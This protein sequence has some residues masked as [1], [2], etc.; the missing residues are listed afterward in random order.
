[1]ALVQKYHTDLNETR[2]GVNKCEHYY[3]PNQVKQEYYNGKLVYN[4]ALYELEITDIVPLDPPGGKDALNA[5]HNAI[6]S[7]KTDADGTV[8][9]EI[10]YKIYPEDLD[11]PPND[12]DEPIYGEFTVVQDITGL[13]LIGTYEQ[14]PKELSGI[15]FSDLEI[16]NVYYDYNSVEKMIPAKG[17]EAQLVV[18]YRAKK[19][20]RYTTGNVDGGYEY[21]VTTSPVILTGGKY[22]YSHVTFNDN[23]E[24]YAE[25][26]Y[27]SIQQYDFK[28][29]YVQKLQITI[30]FTSDEIKD[31]ST[32]LTKEWVSSSTSTDIICYQQHNTIEKE[33]ETNKFL[34]IT[35]DVA[36]AAP[37]TVVLTAT[38]YRT[39]KY[40]YTSKYNT[41]EKEEAVGGN[42]HSYSSGITSVYP[43][44]WTNKTQLIQVNVSGNY[45]TKQVTHTVTITNGTSTATATI[46]QDG[47]RITG[48]IKRNIRSA[49]EVYSEEISA[50][51]TSKNAVQIY[52]VVT[53]DL[54]NVWAS[55]NETFLKNE[56]VGVAASS[57]SGNT[58]SGTGGTKIGTIV[59]ADSRGTQPD[60][61]SRPVYN[62]TYA[63]CTYE[64]NT[65]T[66][67]GSYYV[68]QE[69]NMYQDS[70]PVYYLTSDTS[71]INVDARGGSET[72]TVYSYAQVL[73]TYSSTAQEYADTSVSTSIK[74]SNTNI[75]TVSPS[76]ITGK[77]KTFTVTVKPNTSTSSYKYATVTLTQSSSSKQLTVE[78][79]QENDYLIEQ[80]SNYIAQSISAEEIPASGGSSQVVVTYS[81]TCG[82][83]SY[84]TG[85]QIGNG[86]TSTQTVNATKL[87]TNTSTNIGTASGG[88]VSVGSRGQV[89]GSVRQVYKVT[90]GSTSLG[91][92]A[93]TGYVYQQAN[94]Y[95]DSTTSDSL[96]ISK[97]SPSGNIPNTGGSATFAVS[98]T[99]TGTVY[100]TSGSYTTTGNNT[101]Y[102]SAS[103]A[104]Y[105]S[106][107]PTT[108]TGNGNVILTLN[109]SYNNDVKYTVTAET[110]YSSK[111]AS[112]TQN[113]A[114]IVLD[115]NQT[116]YEVDSEATTIDIV[117]TSTLNGSVN[118]PNSGNISSNQSWAKV[119]S[120]TS[121]GTECITTVSISTNPNTTSRTATITITATGGSNLS[122]TKT[123]TIVQN[124]ASVTKPTKSVKFNG[125]FYLSGTTL[126]IQPMESG[127]TKATF[128]AKE[129]SDYVYTGGTFSYY[130]V[131]SSNTSTSGKIKQTS[132]YSI[133]VN[134][135]SS[136]AISLSNITGLS[137]SAMFVLLYVDNKLFETYPIDQ[138]GD[139]MPD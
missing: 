94:E 26:L 48:T 57:I 78:I 3:G 68:M 33:I 52:V 76:S 88:V 56:S 105:K 125:T 28:I 92:F 74:S 6:S 108:I 1:M 54:Y 77:N 131:V 16:L 65:I 81:K 112:V 97:T 139:E 99:Y 22:D 14:T 10:P 115:L 42:I 128:S 130:F 38:S 19:T 39:V 136:T 51:G 31:S 79:N 118:V 135:G 120:T 72:V 113:G 45:S 121:Y 9:Y 126:Q 8:N 40:E 37:T 138:A 35:D 49:N 53:Y 23:G 29:A 107:S 103:P 86:T 50:I 123:V 2:W 4:N 18:E 60:E 12:T 5:I 11:I 73:R 47:D 70:D 91:S 95:I 34:S 87:T 122:I 59:Y 98:A 101:A 7:R 66:F 83:Y 114:S 127:Y 15:S 102:I 85:N 17:G 89:T 137:S 44:N 132:T 116:V 13:R 24:V 63:S 93:I 27:D 110:N 104:T 36:D 62:I 71:Y 55:T 133:T 41:A 96:T 25:S 30:T 117:Y 134:K 119:G 58:V 20:Y 109:P 67:D 46:V 64:N 90:G 124:G 84:A 100:Y 111:S 21:G 32:T 43:N 61:Y 106:L 80:C 69:P 129:D 82:T 75:V